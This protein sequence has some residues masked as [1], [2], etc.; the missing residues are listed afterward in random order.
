MT[1]PAKL[2]WVGAVSRVQITNGGSEASWSDTQELNCSGSELL[3][4]QN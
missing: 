3:Q 2:M 1:R 4:T